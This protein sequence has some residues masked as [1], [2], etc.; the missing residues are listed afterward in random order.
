MNYRICTLIYMIYM[1]GCS[2]ILVDG[3]ILGNA[4]FTQL[5]DAVPVEGSDGTL[6][7]SSKIATQAKATFVKVK[8]EA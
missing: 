6:F 4:I 1:I 8:N 2:Y 5:D 3:I 7:I